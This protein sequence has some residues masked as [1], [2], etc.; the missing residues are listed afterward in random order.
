MPSLIDSDLFAKLGIAG[1]LTPLLEI[2]GIEPSECRRLPALPHMLRRGGLRRLYGDAAC[3]GLIATAE[4]IPIAP[5][6]STVWLARLAGVPQIDPGEAQLLACAAEHGLLLVTGDKRALI[7]L[8]S[9]EGFAE[10]LSGRV[11]SLEAAALALCQRLGDEYVR[12]AV[13]PLLA[14]DRSLRI[15]FSA[16]NAKPRE[17]I[18]SYFESLK[19]EVAP[20]ALWEPR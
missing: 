9:I 16:S 19:R 3:D 18:A 17:A 2:L 5:A 20:L 1:L 15:W 6:A 14:K 12:A 11:V 8:A 7:A 10:P 4:A 13:A